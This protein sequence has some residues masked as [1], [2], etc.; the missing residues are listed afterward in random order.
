MQ[1]RIPFEKKQRQHFSLPF[2]AHIGCVVAQNS[3]DPAKQDR[4]YTLASLP[5]YSA[6]MRS[7]LLLSAAI[8]VLNKTNNNGL[9]S[10]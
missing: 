4:W 3:A 1:P 8:V 9:Y 10:I 2:C 7:G 5:K 6:L